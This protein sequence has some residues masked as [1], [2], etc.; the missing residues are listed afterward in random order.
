MAQSGGS[1]HNVSISGTRKSP[2]AHCRM[3]Q[4]LARDTG[5]CLTA[6]CANIWHMAQSGGSLQNAA[7]PSQ[8]CLCVKTAVIIIIIIIIIK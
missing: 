5:R 2:V 3:C 4:Y 7:R 8:G 1:L 6:E